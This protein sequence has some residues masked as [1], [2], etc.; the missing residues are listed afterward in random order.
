[1]PETYTKE[2]IE[3][4]KRLLLDS[5]TIKR[6]VT[7]IDDGEPT[8]PVRVIP[9]SDSLTVVLSALST[10]ERERDENKSKAEQYYKDWY[11]SKAEFGDITAK[12]RD[13]VRTAL[14]QVA[15]LEARLQ[16]T[17]DRAVEWVEAD[18]VDHR[19]LRGNARNDLR[20]AIVGK[21]EG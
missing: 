8:T 11:A 6:H 16:G 3:E 13:R 12:L 20:A 15:E 9:L 2:Q 1:M 18:P 7:I 14:A 4:A 5:D 19:G 17:A 21:K 10:A